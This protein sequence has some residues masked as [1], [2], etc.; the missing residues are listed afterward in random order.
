MRVR[1]RMRALAR[2]RC[3]ECV[4]D[5]ALARAR[6]P[7]CEHAHVRASQ[8]RMRL[9]QATGATA[10]RMRNENTKLQEEVQELRVKTRDLEKDVRRKEEQYDREREKSD[11]LRSEMRERDNDRAQLEDDVKA[12]R[13]QARTSETRERACKSCTQHVVSATGWLSAGCVLAA[14]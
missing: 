4:G 2:T 14:V 11:Q 8:T 1:I 7:V 9:L 12:L 13:E 5:C 10:D 6:V 3:R